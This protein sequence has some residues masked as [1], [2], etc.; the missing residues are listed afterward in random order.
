MAVE[1]VTVRCEEVNQLNDRFGIRRDRRESFGL[2][3][4]VPAV[5]AQVPAE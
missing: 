3:A 4:Q 1:C 5:G 2:G